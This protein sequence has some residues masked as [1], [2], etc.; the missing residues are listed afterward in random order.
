VNISIFSYY[1]LVIIKFEYF[2]WISVPQWAIWSDWSSCSQT[3]GRGYQ[4]R[5]RLCDNEYTTEDGHVQTCAQAN[6]ELQS[7]ETRECLLNGTH[8]HCTCELLSQTILS[9]LYIKATQGNLKMWPLW[10]VTLYIQWL[11][12][13]FIN[14][15][16]EAALYIQWLYVL[17]IY[18]E[19]EA[20]LY[21]QCLYV[22]FINREYEAAL[23]IQW[24]YA[25][26]INR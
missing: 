7:S 25:V 5:M 22:L 26:F 23:Y 19:Y 8:P 21:R 20:A 2:I 12:V 13:L 1:F 9:N 10:A 6:S 14:R 17:F 15:E 24:L 4:T 16:Y 18:R 3:C 11:Y